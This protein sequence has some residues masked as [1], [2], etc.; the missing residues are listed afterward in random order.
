MRNLVLGVAVG[1]FV[2]AGGALAYSHYLGDGSL[3]EG[4]QQQLA[5]AQA[6]LAQ[7]QSDK[8]LLAQE[9]SGE[10]EQLNQVI[11]SNQELRKQVAD[12]GD[13][14]AAAPVAPQGVPD[15]GP[16]MWRGLAGA[17][18]GMN[19]RSPQQRM[20]LL[21]ARL[22]LTPDQAE[23]LKA[24]MEADDKARRDIF[25]QAREDHK[26]PDF[27][28]LGQIHN[29][30]DTVATVLTQGQQSEY[31]QVQADE[32]AARAEVEA[33]RQ[34]DDV[35]PLL[36]LTDDQ[37]EKAV[38]AIYDQMV[39]QPDP[40]KAL[41]SPNG[42]STFAKQ[43]QGVQG[44]MQKV[45]S[46]DQYALYQQ[47]TAPPGDGNRPAATGTPP[48]STNASGT[49]TAVTSSAGTTNAPSTDAGSTTNTA[50]TNAAPTGTT[51]DGTAASTNAAPTTN[52]PTT[53]AASSN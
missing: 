4:L 16:Q 38:S 23:K 37:K 6:K 31:A 22:Q 13:T 17:F 32:K 30:D 11:A 29:L 3:L 1:L 41:A 25:R 36:Q 9:N 18:R 34:V 2:G 10:S 14:P 46:P 53:N 45:L 50:S 39:N 27:A 15:F 8:K 35:M 12:H 28:A 19:F 47:A 26:A 40:L 42:L 48:A 24:A 43:A 7:A 20:L 21:Q 33:T 51:T 49:T 44:I 52:A 5:D